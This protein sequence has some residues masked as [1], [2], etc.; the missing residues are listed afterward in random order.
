MQKFMRQSPSPSAMAKVFW[1]RQML[2][3][4]ALFPSPLPLNL[5]GF[6]FSVLLNS[7]GFRGT[8]PKTLTPPRR[9]CY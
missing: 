5:L 8:F 7:S 3:F 2:P 6:D 4:R 1:S 9:V